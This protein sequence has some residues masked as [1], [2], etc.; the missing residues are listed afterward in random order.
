MSQQPITDTDVDD[1][2]FVHGAVF[3]QFLNE[4]TQIG[5][6]TQCSVPGYNLPKFTDLRLIFN[7]YLSKLGSS[8]LLILGLN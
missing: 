6:G 7:C 5:I 4:S 2:S 3:L 1:P 8:S